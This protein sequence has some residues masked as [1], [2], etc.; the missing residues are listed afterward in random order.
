MA[1]E[2]RIPKVFLNKNCPYGLPS[3]QCI[4][5]LEGQRHDIENEV[6]DISSLGDWWGWSSWWLF[7]IILAN[8]VLLQGFIYTQVLSSW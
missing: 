7:L 1:V 6:E 4:G 3:V 2:V 8:K 5:V